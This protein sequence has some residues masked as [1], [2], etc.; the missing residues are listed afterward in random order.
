MRRAVSPMGPRRSR[1]P[2]AARH[3]GDDA[4]MPWLDLLLALPWPALSW[5]VLLPLLWCAERLYR[6]RA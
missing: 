3:H 2:A 1:M 5:W 4:P 6:P